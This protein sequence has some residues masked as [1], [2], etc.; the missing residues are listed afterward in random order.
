M[1][2]RKDLLNTLD[3]DASIMILMC[4]DHISDLVRASSV[5]RSWRHSGKIG[6]S[7]LLFMSFYLCLQFHL[8]HN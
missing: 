2:A 6:L 8:Y 1:G 5:S 7:I 3:T 4:L